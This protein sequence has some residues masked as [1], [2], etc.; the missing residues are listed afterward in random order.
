MKVGTTSPRT[1]LTVVTAIFFMWGFITAFNDVLIPHLKS[2]F[3]L[4]YTEVMLVQ[5]T[6]FGAYFL[7]SLPSGKVV[8]RLGYRLGIIIGLVVTG[9]GA[10]LFL[11]AATLQWYPLFLA[12]FFVLASGI[13]LLQVAANPYVSLLGSARTASSRLNLAQALN[14]LGTTIAPKLGGLLILST[15]VLGATELAKLPA[16]QQLVYKAQQAHIVQGPYLGIA[17]VLFLLAIIVWI[18]HLPPVEGADEQTDDPRHTFKDAL[19]HPRVWLGMA[20]IFV[21][22]G[23]EVSIGSFMINYISLPQIGDMAESRAAGFVSLYWGGAMVGRFIGAALLTRIDTRKLLG[24]NATI[25][26]LLVLTTML[27]HGHVAMWSVVG[28]GLFN[29]IMFPSIFTLGIEKFGPLTGKVS[30]LLVMAIVGGAVV[31]L[32]QGALADHIGVQHAFVLPMLCYI[33]ILFYGL[34]GS[35]TA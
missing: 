17:I 11:P 10:L 9:I 24:F 27:T 6:F 26:V 32:A 19:A 21:Y 2:V 7:M 13:T 31:P 20:A 30:S 22:V 1:A 4:N 34:K 5:F 12:A 8:S 14:S 18:F 25:A 33:Y 16:A 15:A 28:I 23:A 29:S 35:R 3:T